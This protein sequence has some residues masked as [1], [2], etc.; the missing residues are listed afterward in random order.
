MAVAREK[1]ERKKRAKKQRKALSLVNPWHTPPS[2]GPPP[3][4]DR[5]SDV[6]TSKK[7]YST[8]YVLS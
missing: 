7:L 6:T 4:L 1:T 3:S 5:L 2:Q 8:A